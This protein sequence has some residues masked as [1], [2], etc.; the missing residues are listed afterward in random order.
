MQRSDGRLKVEQAF[1]RIECLLIKK[2]VSP[3][4][5]HY[6]YAQ[7]ATAV[8]WNL[9]TLFARFVYILKTIPKGYFTSK[10]ESCTTNLKS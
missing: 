6:M 8:L 7:I 10:S 5:G 9:T 2:T 1:S 4:L 3:M